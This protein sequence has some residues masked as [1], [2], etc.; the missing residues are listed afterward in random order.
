MNA[1]TLSENAQ[2]AIQWLLTERNCSQGKLINSD[3]Q[4]MQCPFPDCD[5]S[6]KVDNFSVNV[7]SAKWFCQ[8]CQTGGIGLDGPNGLKAKLGMPYE[9][10]FSAEPRSDK[11][12]AEKKKTS[13]PC[14]LTKG[15]AEELLVP[16][17]EYDDKH[18]V[19]V[20]DKFIQSRGY[21]KA[22]FLS[23]F[24]VRIGDDGTEFPSNTLKTDDIFK[25]RCIHLFWC[26]TDNDGNIVHLLRRGLS[27]DPKIASKTMNSCGPKRIY[28]SKTPDDFITDRIVIVEGITDAIAIA[29]FCQSAA[30]LGSNVTSEYQQS[31]QLDVFK[32]KDVIY[33]VDADIDDDKVQESMEILLGVAKSVIRLKPEQIVGNDKRDWNDM[34]VSDAEHLKQ[35]I[36]DGIAKAK[37][38]L[39][40]KKEIVVVAEPVTELKGEVSDFPESAWRGIFGW[41]RDA[42]KGTTEAPEQYHFAVLKTVAGVLL[43]RSVWVWS[44]G[45][46]YPAFY[47]VLE[48]PSTQARKTTAASRGAE[49]LEKV[50]P[51]VLQLNG[52]ATAEG[53]LEQLRELTP[54]EL[55]DEAIAQED[56]QRTQSCSDFEG[57]RCLVV[58][59]EFATLLRKAMQE[60]SSS[61]IPQLTQIYDC[62]NFVQNPTKVNPIKVRMPVLGI[63]GLTTK[64]WLEGNLKIDDVFGGFGN[65]FV[66]YRW[67]LTFPIPRPPEPQMTI[68]NE[69][70]RTLHEVR[71]K[72]KT[73]QTEF[74]FDEK[75]SEILDEWYIERWY[76]KYAS[77]LDAV[78]VKRIDENV[79]KLALLYAVLEN[80]ADDNKIHADQL[81]TA[82]E[83]G[84]WW[85][86]SVLS[87]FG[88]FGMTKQAQL[89]KKILDILRKG[90]IS[91]RELQRR[92]TIGLQELGVVLNPLVKN[93]EVAVETVGRSQTLKLSER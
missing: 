47:T 40:E 49:L 74:S 17:G 86:E 32:D 11:P 58:L 2:E 56:K 33:G 54:E 15:Q 79:R 19:F 92:L 65:R 30:L 80:E 83:V 35:Y 66:F 39:A 16:A 5:G 22:F 59:N 73:R 42:Q 55:D 28:L 78:I 81:E 44:G 91:R 24:D 34:L 10:T 75:A 77:E 61:I 23:A 89:E 70:V 12:K 14:L 85:E 9:T 21:D 13:Q 67:T 7:N 48:G 27:A 50:D 64:T 8:R 90:N 46:L 76:R 52:L 20:I 88:T 72:R 68:I 31:G 60:S 29:H 18:G 87:L 38:F 84:N 3:E 45:Q 26:Q 62:R 4:W 41:Y 36:I 1:K 69:I 6:E 37:P 25:L 53:L 82:I 63:I 43:G 57:Y 93:G 71:E 51:L